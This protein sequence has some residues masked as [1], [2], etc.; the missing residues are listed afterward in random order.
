MKRRRKKRGR[1]LRETGSPVFEPPDANSDYREATK[2]LSGRARRGDYRRDKRGGGGAESE[3]EGRP[4]IFI[5]K[6]KRV[7]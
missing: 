5:K 4:G 3:E 7:Q 2:Q 6:K 1:R